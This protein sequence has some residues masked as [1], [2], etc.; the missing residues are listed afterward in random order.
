MADNI[1]VTPGTGKTVAADDIGGVLHQRVK[2]VLGADATSD[3]DVSSANPMPVSDAG[4]SLT[5][6]GSVAASN[7]PSTVDTNSGNKSASTVRVVLATDQPAL[8]NKL[9]VTPDLPSGASTAAKQP[10]L[11]TAGTPSA[12]VITVQ[13][14]TS[15]TALKV[16][17]TGGSFP[18][19]DSGGSLTVDNGGTF[20]TQVDGAALTALQLIDDPVA[21]DDTTT[22][23]TGTTKVMGI[24]AVAAPTD[25]SVN[26]ND[27]GMPAMTTDRK[28]HVSV[29]DALPAGTNAIGKLSANSG[30]DIGDVDVT[31]V[32]TI[33]PG[34]AATSLGKAEDAA[35]S[36]GD[37]GVYALAVRDDVPAAHSGT[38]GDYESLHTNR[39]G[40]LWVTPGPQESDLATQATTHVKKYYTNAG[41]VT[42][43]IIWSPAA[44][45]RWYVTDIFINVSAAA[46]VTLEDDLAGGDEVV[47]K[48]ELAANSGWSH[49][50][51]TPLYSGED[52]ADL[53]I[54]TSAGN[55]YVT[56][57]GYEI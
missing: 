41:A 51:E 37:T 24:G 17:G 54:T 21:T 22:H 31:T 56:I 47:W 57:T 3:G 55:V 7:F 18:V 5:V 10:A 29:Q 43:G 48:A 32:G 19:T 28:L 27:I 16:D 42:D 33:T 39:D 11:G 49:S 38:D 30:V 34:T 6:D 25:A 45:K 20:A 2:V 40:M 35:H 50:F 36:N 23:S 13:G 8:T 26:A 4:G 9:L 52:A 14:V 15:M 46:T 1:D 53:I 12:D 44:G